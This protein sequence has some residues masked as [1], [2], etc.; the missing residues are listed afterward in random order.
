MLPFLLAAAPEPSTFEAS[1]LHGA[2]FDRAEFRMWLP[3]DPRGL[4]AIVVL[5]PGSN[6]DGRAMIDDADWQAFAVRNHTA[7]VGCFFADKPH[8]KSYIEDYV[9]VSRGSGAALV[10]AVT[11]LAGSAKHREIGALPFLLWGL[12]AGGEF[13]YEFAMWK[14]ERVLAFVVNKGG[15]YYTA[16]APPAARDVPALL[17]T[18]EKDIESRSKV[19][20]GLFALNRRAGALWALVSE[21][22][23]G[24]DV[25][26]SR[27]LGITFFEDVLGLRMPP[28]G[29]QPQPAPP[30]RGFIGDPDSKSVHSASSDPG[31]YPTVWLPSE[32]LARA[33][34]SIVAPNAKTP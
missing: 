11:K 21:P 13:D 14:P 6:Q 2:N 25:G 29:A 8:P 32:R 22:G 15:V 34:L 9:A 17:F 24:H 33:W 20:E 30:A 19:V 4:R 26:R 23:V 27:E 5:V 3:P 16:L 7:L 31:D 1:A 12:S 10:A 18:G 28:G